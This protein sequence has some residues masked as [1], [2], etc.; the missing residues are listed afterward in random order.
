MALLFLFLSFSGIDLFRGS[1]CFVYW[2][3]PQ[4]GLTWGLNFISS[5]DASYFLDIVVSDRQTLRDAGD[6]KREK[7]TL[8]TFECCLLNFR[9]N[10][11]KVDDSARMSSRRCLRWFFFNHPNPA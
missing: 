1:D 10:L 11:S 9:R 8:G 6:V 3:D 7:K 4:K 2:C 5:D